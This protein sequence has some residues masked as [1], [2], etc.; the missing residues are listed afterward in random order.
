MS[1]LLPILYSFRR[2][3]YAMRTRMALVEA[4]IA[5]ELREVDLSNKPAALLEAS[6]KGTVP[7]LVQPDGK[8]I[9]ESMDIMRWAAKQVPSLAANWMEVGKDAQD[10]MEVFIKQNDAVFKPLLDRYKY[11]DRYNDSPT[12]QIAR[13]EAEVL[14]LKPLEDSLQ[15]NR[16]LVTDQ[17][18]LADIAIF[19]FMRQ[20]AK[21][22][23]IWFTGSSYVNLQAWLFSLLDSALFRRVMLKCAPWSPDTAPFIIAP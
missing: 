20:F 15:S 12:G 21:T 2:C 19:P 23:L 22:N 5:F 1:K 18:T 11:P 17:V 14:F 10:K 6:P 13:Q 9:D 3:P 7:V 16:F 4:G 8:V